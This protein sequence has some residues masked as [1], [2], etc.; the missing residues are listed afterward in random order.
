LALPSI[1]DGCFPPSVAVQSLRGR[2]RRLKADRQLSGGKAASPLTPSSGRSRS[3]VS[4]PNDAPASADTTSIP[5][6]GLLSRDCEHC[7]RAGNR[8]PRFQVSDQFGL[9]DGTARYRRNGGEHRL[10]SPLL[11]GHGATRCIAPC[12]NVGRRELY[13]LRLN[14]RLPPSIAVQSLRGRPRRLKADRQL[15]GGK[16]A[17]PLTPNTDVHGAAYLTQ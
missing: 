2:P 3:D 16:A 1:A 11:Y 12:R 17:R 9:D 5:S 15:S 14:V 4:W 10:G 8:R 13:Q 6:A 7:V